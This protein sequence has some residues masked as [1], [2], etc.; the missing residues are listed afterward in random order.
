MK[1]LGIKDVERVH[2][3]GRAHEPFTTE[4]FAFVEA[5]NRTSKGE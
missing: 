2:L 5:V 3:E 1:A 4:V